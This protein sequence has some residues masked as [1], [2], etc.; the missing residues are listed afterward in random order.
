MYKYDLLE[1]YMGN[2]LIITGLSS[3][4]VKMYIKNIQKVV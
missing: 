4:T 1:E 3:N 2:I